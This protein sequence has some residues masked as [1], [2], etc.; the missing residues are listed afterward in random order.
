MSSLTGLIGIRVILNQ[1]YVGMRL[2]LT[3]TLLTLLLGGALSVSAQTPT[4]SSRASGAAAAPRPTYVIEDIQVKGVESAQTRQFVIQ[5]SGLTQGQRITLPAGNA[6]SEA[7]RSIYELRLF[8]DVAIYRTKQSGNKVTLIIE[9]T[10]EPTLGGYKLKGIDGGDREDLKKKLPLLKGSP[11]RPSDV[12]RSKQI[13]KN[14]Y[15]KEGYLRTQVDVVRRTSDGN[16]VTLAFNVDRRKKIEVERIRFFGNEQFDDGDL[17]GA[18]KKTRENRWWRIW[19]G[20]KFKRNAYEKDLDRV[21][22]HYREHGYY[23]AQIVRDSVYYM[24]NEGLG[25]DIKVREGNRYYVSDITWEGN[26]VYPD[27]ILSQELG[28]SEGEV[29]NGKALDENL[30]GGQRKSGVLGLY[31][32]RGYMRANVQ[33]TVRVV[34]DDSLNITMDVQEGEV[35]TFGDINITGNTKT[36]DYVIRRELYTV[37]GDRFSR[38]SIQESIRRLNQLNYFSQKSL[39]GGPDLSVNEEKKEAELTYSVEETGSDQLQLSGTFGQFGL[40]LQLGFQFNNFSA[41]NLFD[42]SAW[43]PLPSGDG[44]KLSVNVRTNGTFFQNYSLSFTEPWFGGNPTPVGGSLSYSKYTR[45]VFGGRRGSGG[46]EDGKFQNFS[47]NFFVRQRLDWPD[48]KFKIGSRVGYQLYNNRGRDPDGQRRPLFTSVP[49]GTSQSVTFRQSLS[50]NSVDNPQFPHEGSKF[51]LSVEV[52]PPVGDLVQYHKWRFKTSWNVPFGED[53][54]FGV[55]TDFG[56]IGSI[57][58]EEVRF[59]TFEVGGSPFDYQGGT[60]GTDPV[61][62]R[63]YPRGVIG[64]LTPAP[65]GTLQPQGG[66]VLNKYTSE[67]RWKAVESKQLQARPYLFMDA[68]N[69]WSSL[70]AYSPADLFRSAGIGVKLFLP[71]VGMIELNYGYNFDE[72][73]PLEGGTGQPG[74]TFQFSLGQ[75]FSGGR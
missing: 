43:R 53:F 11:V 74:W 23:D 67:F 34:G 16:R 32:D 66:Q 9:V 3:V 39:A 68:A 20:E 57:T 42:A 17:R 7:I 6:V 18:M 36:K 46:I 69:A 25:I 8:S 56:Y 5:T 33:P 37:P 24:G 10:P 64:P 28:L 70:N 54:S 30:Y 35:Y 44:Q 1:R 55:G 41:Q 61:F 21:I 29:Y 47:A 2:R 59:E 22:D 50:R 40:V 38:S 45:S 31:M 51:S 73:V 58:G 63:G 49:F 52:A 65:G 62:M 15:K 71:I 14:F 4:R 72:F 75:G 12:E 48:D 60:F 27:R 13:I 26:T 19:K